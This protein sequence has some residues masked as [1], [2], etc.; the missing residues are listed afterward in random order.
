[1]QL[2]ITYD[3][4]ISKCGEI[5]VSVEQEGFFVTYRKDL[6]STQTLVFDL[7]PTKA[8]EVRLYNLLLLFRT[9]FVENTLTISIPV[10]V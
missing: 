3:A 1:V 7:S 4:L 10:S 9:G 5:A 6:S 8:N 2:T